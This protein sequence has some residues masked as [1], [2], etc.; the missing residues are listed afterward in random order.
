MAIKLSSIIALSLVYISISSAQQLKYPKPCD[1]KLEGILVATD[2]IGIKVYSTPKGKIVDHLVSVSDEDKLVLGIV[3]HKAGWIKINYDST[4]YGWIKSDL[5]GTWT[6][7]DNVVL[8]I[9]PDLNSKI[10]ASLDKEGY[11]DQFVLI[12]GCWRGW[13][14]V[15]ATDS[16]GKTVY[17]WLDPK[18]QCSN[19]YTSCGN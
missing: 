18:H 1:C 10:I 6:N 14:Y 3:G 16:K 7:P 4:N 9:K 19:P 15:K 5:I 12:Y 17:G 13:A 11:S 2:S 8:H